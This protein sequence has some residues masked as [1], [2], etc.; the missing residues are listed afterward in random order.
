MTLIS[1]LMIEEY[2]TRNVNVNRNEGERQTREGKK[3]M[4]ERNKV[5]KNYEG[6]G[7]INSAG[8]KDM[9]CFDLVLI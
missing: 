1:P 7:G 6:R 9:K 3:K 5:K 2:N 8:S 4:Q